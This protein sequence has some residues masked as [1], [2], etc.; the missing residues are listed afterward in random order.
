MPVLTRSGVSLLLSDGLETSLFLL[1]REFC[2]DPAK[3]FRVELL[4]LARGI[5][6]H[7]RAEL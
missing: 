6:R 3:G 5:A 7:V 1:S 2:S 4:T